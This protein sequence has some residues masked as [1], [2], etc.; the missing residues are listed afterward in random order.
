MTETRNSFKELKRFGHGVDDLPL[1]LHRT[2]LLMDSIVSVVRIVSRSVCPSR[3]THID[4]NGKERL[5]IYCFI[6]VPSF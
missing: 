2:T 6:R 5:N 1:L 3:D 4:S